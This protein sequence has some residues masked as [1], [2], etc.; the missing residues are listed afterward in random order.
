[1]KFLCDQMLCGL[2]KWLR[3]AG[4][5]TEIA[6]PGI[7]DRQLLN[8][9]KDEARI[10]L[11][12]DGRLPCGRDAFVP[13]PVILS[14]NRI[15]PAVRELT[16]RLHIDWLRRSFTRCLKD[17][18]KLRLATREEAAHA[19]RCSRELPGPMMTCPSCQRLYW[20]GSHYR[21]MKGKLEAFAA[22][23]TG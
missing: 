9:A 16:R 3:A 19:P 7:D 5:D 10:V 21:R 17:N 12:C 8:W 11:S 15:E 22:S 2:G 6:T 23:S 4:Y 18:T 20:P 14:T 1:M 13:E